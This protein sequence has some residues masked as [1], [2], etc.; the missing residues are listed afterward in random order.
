MLCIYLNE[1]E[2][3][4]DLQEDV[5]DYIEFYNHELFHET[6]K[7]KKPMNVYQEGIKAS[8][9]LSKVS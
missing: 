5:S 9:A 6:L 1:Y 2:T 4:K 8:L 7:Y 3:I